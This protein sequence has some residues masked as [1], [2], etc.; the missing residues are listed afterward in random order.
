MKNFLK[1]MFAVPFVIISGF[2]G[3]YLLSDLEIMKMILFLLY[4]IGMGH[5]IYQVL[6]AIDR[7]YS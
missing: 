6:R 7:K 3:V 1:A 5:V 2:L 4:A